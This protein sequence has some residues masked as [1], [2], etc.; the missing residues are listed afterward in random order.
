MLKIDITTGRI[1]ALGDGTVDKSKPRRFWQCL[2]SFPNQTS[3]ANRF[4]DIAAEFIE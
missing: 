3:K 1:R 2:K 4:G